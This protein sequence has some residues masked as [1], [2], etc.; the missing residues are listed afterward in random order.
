[1]KKKTPLAMSGARSAQH[2]VERHM[3]VTSSNHARLVGR[4][5]ILD[6]N[7]SVLSAVLLEEPERFMDEVTHVDFLALGVVNAI[8]QISVVLLKL[9]EDR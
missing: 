6:V 3:A 5:H 8:A 7:E 2:N 1:L 4:N 9:I